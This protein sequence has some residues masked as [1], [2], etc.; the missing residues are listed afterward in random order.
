MEEI[1]LVMDRLLSNED[2]LF[3]LDHYLY[4][5]TTEIVLNDDLDNNKVIEMLKAK[6]YLKYYLDKY[7]IKE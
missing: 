2:F 6:Q 4:K 5:E 1:Y 3:F 7:T